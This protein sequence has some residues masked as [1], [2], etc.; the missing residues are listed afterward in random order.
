MR[1][2]VFGFLLA[3]FVHPALAQEVGTIPE[4]VLLDLSRDL[5]D[6]NRQVLQLQEAQAEA[7]AAVI[8]PSKVIVTSDSASV[9]AGAGGWFI[10][11]VFT[12]NKG[13]AFDVVDKVSDWYA[14]KS[15]PAKVGWIK[16]SNVV[17][18]IPIRLTAG[19]P[20]G[21]P[22]IGSPSSTE[23]VFRSLTEGATKLRDK[24]KNNPHVFVKGFSVKLG[25]PPS[26]DISFEFK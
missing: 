18:D 20:T 3:L 5:A 23:D 21:V 15:Y 9:K 25:L 16:A 12:A 7:Q 11:T 17:P 26:L 14:I 22:V 6:L 4:D 10:D 19:S 13:Q 8:R 24:W 1:V 2:L